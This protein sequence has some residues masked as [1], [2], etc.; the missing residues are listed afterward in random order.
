MVYWS[1]SRSRD[2][3]HFPLYQARSAYHEAEPDLTEPA[4][5]VET[6]DLVLLLDP[7]L[8]S[9]RAASRGPGDADRY[10]SGAGG[11][12]AEVLDAPCR[13]MSADRG[14]FELLRLWLLG[15]LM[16]QQQGKRFLL[17]YLAPAWSSA[18]TFLAAAA[19]FRSSAERAAQRV[20]WEEIHGYVAG[21]LTQTP[22]ALA[23][24][25]YLEEKA[26]G[27][28]QDGVLRRAFLLQAAAATVP[29]RG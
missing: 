9:V 18:P 21:G 8:G 10:Q 15:S 27:Y 5:I 14:Q 17:L 24:L 11:W 13:E 7:H 29:A 2:G 4:I 16:A 20:S 26:A 3:V 19:H 23:L 25:T 22:G 28:G 1:Y 6:D 12:A